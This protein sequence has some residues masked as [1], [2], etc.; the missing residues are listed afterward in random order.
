MHLHV[1]V[2]PAH[3]C[4]S[5]QTLLYAQLWRSARPIERPLFQSAYNWEGM[6]GVQTVRRSHCR[7]LV[8]RC[9]RGSALEGGAQ[10]GST[11]QGGCGG[12]AGGHK[13][14][15]RRVH[16]AVG[17]QAARLGTQLPKQVEALCMQQSP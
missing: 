5:P 14:T 9:S 6:R 1:L 4:H 12:Q 16:G 8:K 3:A 15:D 7:A 17:R 11:E 13:L 10:Q 2:Q